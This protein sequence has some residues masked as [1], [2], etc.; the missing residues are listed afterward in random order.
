MKYL[1]FVLVKCAMY[2]A[3]IFLRL[4][5]L[6]FIVAVDKSLRLCLDSRDVE[7]PHAS[8]IHLI[9]RNI[10]IFPPGQKISHVSG[11]N[12]LLVRLI[13]SLGDK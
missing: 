7:L 10:I 1:K 6:F 2:L 3:L 12:V 11:I 9:T 4:N 8:R 5:V 13:H